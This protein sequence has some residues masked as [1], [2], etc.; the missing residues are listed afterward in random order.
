MWSLSSAKN[1]TR[2]TLDIQVKLP[3]CRCICAPRNHA[4]NCRDRTVHLWANSASSTARVAARERIDVYRHRHVFV[5][6]L[7]QQWDFFAGPCC[8]EM[9]QE[10]LCFR[11]QPVL[12]LPPSISGRHLLRGPT[13]SKKDVS[14]RLAS[15]T[16]SL[17]LLGAQHHQHGELQQRSYPRPPYVAVWFST[18]AGCRALCRKTSPP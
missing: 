8:S 7:L 3:I 1:E 17:S 11:G 5:R 2:T 4:V 16:P 13:T 15:A 10:V 14:F 12:P 6:P 9:T 18:D